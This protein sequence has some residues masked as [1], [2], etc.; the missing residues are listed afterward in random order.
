MVVAKQNTDQCSG[1][2]GQRMVEEYIRGGHFP[3][4]VARE[5]ELYRRRGEAVEAALRRDLPEDVTWTT[6]DG[7]FFVW[8]HVPGIDT[9]ELATKGAELAVAFVP[10]AAFFAEREEREYLRLSF[11]RVAEED[12]DEG[13]R[14]LGEAISALRSVGR[15]Q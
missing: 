5:Q 13:I 12:I 6:P 14:R 8:V 11:S 10:G 3:A 15:G 1:A 4:Q 2:L 9:V 7:G